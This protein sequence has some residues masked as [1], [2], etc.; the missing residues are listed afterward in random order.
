MTFQEWDSDDEI[1]EQFDD[2]WYDGADEITRRGQIE[3]L[4]KCFEISFDVPE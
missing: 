4:K 1:W 3:W 2:D